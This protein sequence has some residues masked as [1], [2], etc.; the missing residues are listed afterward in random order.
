MLPLPP[1]ILSIIL[2]GDR[3]RFM[4]QENLDRLIANFGTV[5]AMCCLASGTVTALTSF[6]P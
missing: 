3:T 2:V 1:Q 4:L 5:H 6:L